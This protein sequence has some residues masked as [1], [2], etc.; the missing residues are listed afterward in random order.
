MASKYPVP[1][2]RRTEPVKGFTLIELLVVV[3]I[4]G[5]L[6]AV[7]APS[8]QSITMKNRVQAAASEFQSALAMAR[9]EAIKRGGDARITVVANA[10][11]GSVADWSSGLTVF[12]DTTTNAN[13]DAPSSDGSKLIMQTSAVPSG[14]T[15][16]VN[17]NHII[18]NGFGRTIDS[19]GAPRGGT[20]A[21]GSSSSDYICTI[22]S[23]AGR[24]RTTTV[25]NAAYTASGCT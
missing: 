21:F 16:S 8:F 19:T 15:A 12:Y 10:K 3:A 25:S 14:V 13:G 24:T 6:L 2:I 1:K 22:V 7:A 5:I 17:F 11:T 20:A 4:V 18:F 23:L 9:A